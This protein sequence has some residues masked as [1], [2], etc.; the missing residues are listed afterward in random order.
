MIATSSSPSQRTGN[1]FL[2]G[3]GSCSSFR[4]YIDCA[5][6]SLDFGVFSFNWFFFFAAH[7]VLF[8]RVLGL[9]MCLLTT[10]SHL[11]L[12]SSKISILFVVCMISQLRLGSWI[13]WVLLS[14][15]A[16]LTTYLVNNSDYLSSHHCCLRVL[17]P[18]EACK[19]TFSFSSLL[20][21]RG[22]VLCF[23]LVYWVSLNLCFGTM[24]VES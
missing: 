18:K 16:I 3:I 17:S 1:R 4:Q 23:G 19:K 14:T 2:G 9:N 10:S 5:T 20:F 12:E 7:N 13:L 21:I 6:L 8:I 15:F 22:I 11:A 24:E